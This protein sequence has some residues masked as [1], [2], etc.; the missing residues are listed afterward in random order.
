MLEDYARVIAPYFWWISVLFAITALIYWFGVSEYSLTSHVS[1]PGPK[2]WPYVGNL[3]DVA[4]Y[5]GLHKVLIEYG[6]R[7]GKVYKMYLGRTPMI[8]VA[9]P[10]MLK[11]IFVKDFD[12]F[13]NRLAYMRGNP[14]MDKA[15]PSARDD[16]WK[17]IRSILTP[18]FSSRKLK[19]VVP[20]IEDAAYLLLGK[21]MRCA[22]NGKFINI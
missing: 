3:L 9:D 15:L 13:P 5:G 10:E 11:H 22:E 8:T 4:K 21:L 18:T 17:R 16:T 20:I 14:P 1:L 2:P 19:E 12:K 6:K 7:Y